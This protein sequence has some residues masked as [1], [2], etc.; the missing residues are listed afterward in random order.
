MRKIEMK[1]G[2][3]VEACVYVGSAREIN[4]LY[5][6]F[7]KRNIYWP[8]H[9]DY[10]RFNND[11]IYGLHCDYE[12]EVMYVVSADTVLRLLFDVG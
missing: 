12:T 9:C 5:G 11:R 8:S 4:S 10:P 1:N 3:Y 7:A 2:N 6:N